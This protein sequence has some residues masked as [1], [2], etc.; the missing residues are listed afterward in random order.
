M[1]TPYAAEPGGRAPAPG[2]LRVVQ[3]FINSL[4]IE[5]E[6]EEFQ[7]PGQLSA[8]LVSHGLAKPGGPRLTSRDLERTRRFRDL[9]RELAAGNNGKGRSRQLQR[10]LNRELAALSFVA[11]LEDGNVATLRPTGK[12]IDRALSQLAAIVIEEMICGRWS[13]M[14]ECAEDTCRWVFYD[15]SRS[16]T[17]IWCTMADCGSRAKSRAYYRRRTAS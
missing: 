8:W 9:L 5:A 4:D 2:R 7:T 16:R 17:G 1:S 14:K 11:A 15:H 6:T 3:Q 13:R 10:H 12:G